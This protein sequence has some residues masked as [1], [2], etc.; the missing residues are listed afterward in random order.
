MAG[1]LIDGSCIKN[2]LRNIIRSEKIGSINIENGRDGMKGVKTGEERLCQNV[3]SNDR[4]Q[5]GGVVNCRNTSGA[6][7]GSTD[8]VLTSGTTTCCS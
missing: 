8:I 7:Q 4:D 5:K 2:T 3:M 6:R 1:L